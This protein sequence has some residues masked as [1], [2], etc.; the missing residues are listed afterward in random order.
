MA[1][2]TEVVE[3]ADLAPEFP[4]LRRS[5]MNK[6]V[7]LFSGSSTGTVLTD[8]DNAYGIGHHSTQWTNCHLTNVWEPIGAVTL[9][10]HG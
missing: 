4:L 9:K 5:K 2:N 7:V 10:S 6:F 8:P 1:I 3:V